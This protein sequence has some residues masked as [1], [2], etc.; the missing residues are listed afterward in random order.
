M[1]DFCRGK[2]FF[3]TESTKKQSYTEKEKNVFTV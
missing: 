2:I 3:N 1:F